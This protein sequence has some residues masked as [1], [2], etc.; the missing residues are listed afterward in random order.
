MRNQKLREV[1]GLPR[2]SHLGRAVLLAGATVLAANCVPLPCGDS[3]L[4]K[5]FHRDFVLSWH[6]LGSLTLKS[7]S[8]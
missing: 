2:L 8:H 1:K 4:M 6:G 5:D 3:G 7:K